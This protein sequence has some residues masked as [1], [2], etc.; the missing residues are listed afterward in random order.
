MIYLDNAATSFHKPKCVKNA[1]I[2]AMENLT[3][4]PGRSGHKL[5]QDVA[6]EIFETRELLKE[7]FNAKE[8]QVIFTKNCTE[9]LNIAILG[10]LKSGDHVVTS[11]YE[12]NSVLRPLEFLK[13]KGVQVTIIEDDL[14]NFHQVLQ[15]H[16]MP[17]T[18]LVVITSVSNVTGD[19]C[20]LQAVGEVC[21]K[22]NIIYLV[23]GAQGCGHVEIDIKKMNI[24]AIKHSFL[25][26]TQ[27]EK[28]LEEFE[29]KYKELI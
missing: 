23:D 13:T 14:Q 28:L 29:L 17:N 22:N 19:G 4:N 16:I 26:N 24:D 21:K 20:N 2:K 12:H 5:A 10:T 27:K 25:D 18:K 11:V 15:Q 8:H 1:V 6:G 3:A 7:F 9:A